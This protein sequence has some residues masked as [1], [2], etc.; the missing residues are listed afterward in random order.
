MLQRFAQRCAFSISTLPLLARE[1][2]W[3]SLSGSLGLHQ[4][5]R[6]V[7]GDNVTQQSRIER[8]EMLLKTPVV[9]SSAETVHA[10][11]GFCCDVLGPGC[12]RAEG[13]ADQSTWQAKPALPPA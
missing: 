9:V 2:L 13:W 8:V 4:G 7:S 3:G 12:Q 10:M 11:S 6:I 5:I 1:S